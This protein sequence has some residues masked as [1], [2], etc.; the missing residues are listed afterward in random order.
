MCKCIKTIFIVLLL[1]TIS[2][3][4]TKEEV[5]LEE[6]SIE[7][8]PIKK[9]I[10]LVSK[11]NKAEYIESNGIEYTIEDKVFKTSKGNVNYNL[12]QINGLKDK[13]LER[14]INSNIINDMEKN[15][16]DLVNT[17]I[18]AKPRYFY[19]NVVLNANNIFS[20]STECDT[21]RYI[22]G[23]LYNLSDGE[24]IYLKELF[25]A[26][27]D[28]VSL[29]N[30][31]IIEGVIGGY[32]EEGDILTEPFSTISQNQEFV[33]SE[34]Y[35]TISFRR[36]E[37][38]FFDDFQINIPLS[39][40][41]NYVD[42]LDKQVFNRDIF[43]KPQY[44]NKYNNIFI[45]MTNE[46]V[47]IPGGSA[48][49]SY[50]VISGVKDSAVLEQINSTIKN[51]MYEFLDANVISKPNTSISKESF[52][53]VKMYV[54]FNCYGYLCL[55]VD[56]YYNHPSYEAGDLYKAYTFDLKNG[57]IADP[58]E[59]LRAYANKNEGF[60][61]AFAESVRYELK[62]PYQDSSPENVAKIDKLVDYSFI[63][64][65]GQIFF[66]DL[67]NGHDPSIGV[68]FK[69]GTLF[70]YAASSQAYF[71]NALNVSID[72]FFGKR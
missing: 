24:R 8:E 46:I 68:F 9:E 44:I 19:S 36:G 58:K 37:A 13:E 51:S 10:V 40:I 22:D 18:Y 56:G 63:L 5:I 55:L 70:D 23:L 20:I 53:S 65:N 57:T 52:A 69:K 17:S 66:Q 43:E 16:N 39:Q 34:S 38:G 42:I 61:E 41:D 1:L 64:E 32:Y 26:G 47:D 4:S 30:R 48:E 25:T 27:T 14:K 6:T 45:D 72:S 21:S 67:Y 50:P 60:K 62:M 12:I 2:G 31:E 15:M 28:Y 3:C 59:I 33:L 7:R 29:L 49:L 35:L 71:G 54:Y 11:T